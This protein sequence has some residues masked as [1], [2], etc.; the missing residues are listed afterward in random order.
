MTLQ[1]QA[2]MGV[3]ATALGEHTADIDGS[4]IVTTAVEHLA[5]RG[6]SSLCSLVCRF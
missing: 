6:A 5:L 2:G 1:L 4:S 3:E